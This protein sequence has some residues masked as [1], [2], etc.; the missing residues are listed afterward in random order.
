[1][2][3]NLLFLHLL[4]FV[5]LVLFRGYSYHTCRLVSILFYFTSIYRCANIGPRYHTPSPEITFVPTS[6]ATLINGLGRYS[7]GPNSTLA[8]INV[9]P[10]K[11][12]RF[13]LVSI[14]CDPNFVFSIVNHNLVSWSFC[15]R[16][17][18][19]KNLPWFL[20][21]NRG[22]GYLRRTPRCRF[23]SDIRRSTLLLHIKR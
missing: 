5:R 13:R 23:H 17:M 20:D 21:D 16:S 9:S 1:M 8:V 3:F 4:M 10:G 14:S 7:G 19:Q 12:Y 11:R 15:Y 6:D 2:P 18:K 22:R